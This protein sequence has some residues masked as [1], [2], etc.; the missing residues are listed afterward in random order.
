MQQPP[1][2]SQGVTPQYLLEGAVYALEQGGLL[3]HDSMLLYQNGKYA[4]AI[5]IALFAREEVGRYKLLRD[6]RKEMIENGRTVTIEDIETKFS[7]H[8]TKQLRGQFG[9]VLKSSGDDQIGK[10]LRTILDNRPQSSEAHVA[11][12]QLDVIAKQL[13]RQMPYQRHDLRQK[14]LYVE[15][16]DSGASWN[17]PKDQPKQTA[18]DEIMGAINAYSGALDRFTRAGAYRNE[19]PSFYSALEAWEECPTMPKIAN[20]PSGLLP[21]SKTPS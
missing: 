3:L 10:L 6:L 4:S 18:M 20:P 12:A 13:H 21:V 19:D 17:R 1:L 9:V 7:D 8:V 14:S 16:S 15:P 2:P 11:N 5:V